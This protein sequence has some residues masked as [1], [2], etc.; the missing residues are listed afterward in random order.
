ML[1]VLKT[2]WVSAPNQ[3]SC[4][5]KISSPCISLCSARNKHC[6]G[7]D[8]WLYREIPHAC[9]DAGESPPP[10]DIIPTF[11]GD[12]PP[13]TPASPRS[14]LECRNRTSEHI[15]L[16][17]LACVANYSVQ[18]ITPAKI[19]PPSEQRTLKVSDKAL[20]VKPMAR[21]AR[22]RHQTWLQVESDG[23]GNFK[24]QWGG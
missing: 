23:E 17:N 19:S 6:Q 7:S 10:M 20:E 8:S 9:H 15:A 3:R 16:A 11:P 5:Q 18:P 12:V 21:N 1:W 13:Q 4:F 24:D 22:G 14:T 2:N